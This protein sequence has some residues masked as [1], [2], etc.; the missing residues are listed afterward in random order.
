MRATM[1]GFLLIIGVAL[2]A[3]MPFAKEQEPIRI[4]VDVPARPTAVVIGVAPRPSPT[5]SAKKCFVYG[6]RW[7]GPCE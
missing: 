6:G 5:P 7:I 1:K 3:L 4:V 2:L